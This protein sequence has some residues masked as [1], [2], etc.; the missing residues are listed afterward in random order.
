[1]ARY[2]STLVLQAAVS[3]DDLATQT[4]ERGFKSGDA[5]R[6]YLRPPFFA[7]GLTQAE[8]LRFQ[9]AVVSRNLMFICRKRSEINTSAIRGLRAI[10]CNLSRHWVSP[11]VWVPMRV[12]KR[13]NITDSAT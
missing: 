9:S 13:R 1:L 12:G 2:L 3:H 10:R 7:D 4:W 8:R 11:M 6:Q 5:S